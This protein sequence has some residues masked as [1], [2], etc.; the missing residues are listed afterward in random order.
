MVGLPG[1]GIVPGCCVPPG[2]CGRLTASC[3]SGLDV[4]QIVT[5]KKSGG[6]K[7]SDIFTGLEYRG[8]VGFTVLQSVT[9]DD[10]RGSFSKPQQMEKSMGEERGLVGHNSPWPAFGFDILK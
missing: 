5:G 4:A 10:R 7:A 1:V 9:A 2:H 6:S 8:R 3:S